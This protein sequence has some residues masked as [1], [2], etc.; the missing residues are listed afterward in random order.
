MIFSYC[1]NFYLE[2]AA[3]TTTLLR[4]QEL[5]V[6]AN[7][8]FSILGSTQIVNAAKLISRMDQGHGLVDRILFATPLEYR[9][10]LS[11]IEEAKRVL[12]TEVGD[13]FQQLF[14]TINAG[15]QAE[16]K[17]DR[18]Y[19]KNSDRPSCFQ[20]HNGRTS[21]WNRRDAAAKQDM[22]ENIGKCHKIC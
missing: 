6:P 11:E 2:R 16:I 12:F 8:P 15:E 13:D 14:E 3:L 5:Y 18:V 21:S 7:I 10:T 20:P 1:V 17:Y 22:E 9:P 4:K 19:P